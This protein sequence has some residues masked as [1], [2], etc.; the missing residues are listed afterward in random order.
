MICV[1][2][3]VMPTALAQGARDYRGEVVMT[4]EGAP[5]LPWVSKEVCSTSRGVCRN[6]IVN[7]QTGEI[8]ILG[9][10]LQSRFEATGNG[11]EVQRAESVLDKAI[12]LKAAP[13]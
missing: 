2:L 9:S 6:M 13:S 4:A 12:R 10:R 8:A 11:K 5:V 7:S 3:T 1:A